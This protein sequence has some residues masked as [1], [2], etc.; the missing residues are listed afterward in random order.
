LEF[1]KF[2]LDER[3]YDQQARQYKTVAQPVTEAFLDWI[4]DHAGAV[5]ALA[6]IAIGGFTYVLAQVTERQARLALAGVELAQ[7]EFEATHRPWLGVTGPNQITVEIG[8][9]GVAAEVEY[10]LEN[11]GDTPAVDVLLSGALFTRVREPDIAAIQDGYLTNFANVSK[12]G[13]PKPQTQIVFS[14]KTD[15]YR[16]SFKKALIEVERERPGDGIYM[17]LFV[18]TFIYVSSF[19]KSRLYHTA[20]VH[21]FQTRITDDQIQSAKAGTSSLRV[22]DLVRWQVGWSCA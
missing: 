6:T 19:D 11:T 22:V 3:E 4:D 20:C 8:P 18:C 1:S 17:F 13:I 21:S 16:G 2:R 15:T 9:V 14:K 5:T 12:T 10:V 7:R